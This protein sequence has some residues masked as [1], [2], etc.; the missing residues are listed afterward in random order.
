MGCLNIVSLPQHRATYKSDHFGSVSGQIAAAGA[1]LDNLRLMLA[2]LLAGDWP[3]TY[4]GD[5]LYYF[6][7]FQSL[8]DQLLDHGSSDESLGCIVTLCC[9]LIAS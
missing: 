8:H 5:A 6:K 2:N 9:L 1:R 4:K 3:N 7:L